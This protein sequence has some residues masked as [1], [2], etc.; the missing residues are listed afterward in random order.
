MLDRD[1]GEC[2]DPFWCTRVRGNGRFSR[3]CTGDRIEPLTV[4]VVLTDPATDDATLEIDGTQGELAHDVYQ[5]PLPRYSADAGGTSAL[6]QLYVSNFVTNLCRLYQ[7][8]SPSLHCS[9]PDC[10]S[11]TFEGGVELCAVCRNSQYLLDGLCVDT[12]I[13]QARRGRLRGNGRFNRLCQV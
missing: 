9:A 7:A 1:T 5:P 12:F 2:F 3:V 10:H 4:V 11:C 13:C 8:D 6:V